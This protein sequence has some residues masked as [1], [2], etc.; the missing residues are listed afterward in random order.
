MSD[1]DF[2]N[3]NLDGNVG[4]R[5]N[6]LQTEPHEIRKYCKRNLLVERGSQQNGEEWLPPMH[7]IGNWCQE[8]TKNLKL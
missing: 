2:L 3:E 6:S 4:N 5:T 7:M 8:Y 1:K